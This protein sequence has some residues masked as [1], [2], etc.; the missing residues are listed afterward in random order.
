[1]PGRVLSND[2]AALLLRVYHLICTVQRNKEGDNFC[3]SLPFAKAVSQVYQLDSALLMLQKE[4]F[5]A[6]N[7]GVWITGFS[8]GILY[9]KLTARV[10]NQHFLL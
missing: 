9:Q 4:I 10:Q 3:R 1:M 7:N 2:Q 8:S 5:K 6:G